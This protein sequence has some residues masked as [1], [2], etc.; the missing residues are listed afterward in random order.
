MRSWIT[1]RIAPD[2]AERVD[3]S[4]SATL[5]LARTV[6]LETATQQV[7]EASRSVATVRVELEAIPADRRTEV[8]FVDIDPADGRYEPLVGYDRAGAI[9]SRRSTCPAH[10]LDAREADA[11]CRRIDRAEIGS[12]DH[13]DRSMSPGRLGS[14]YD[15]IEHH[16]EQR[17][18]DDLTPAT[19]GF[20]EAAFEAF[21]QEPRRARVARSTAAARR[22]R[23]FQAFPWPTA[24]DEEWRR[25]DIRGCKLDAFAPAGPEEPSAEDR[26][27]LDA[28]LGDPELALRHRHRAGQRRAGRARPIPRKLGGAVFVDLAQAVK[29]HPE[30]LER[31]LLTEAV[32]PAADVFAALH[33][34]FWTG[35]T[36]LYVPKGVKVE[37]PL[38]SLVGLARD[39]R[40]DMNHT[41]VVLEEGAEATLVR[42]TAGR[43]RG[44]APALH[45]GA[46]EIFVGRGARL[47]FVNIQNWDAATWHFSRERALVGPRRRAAVD[48]RRPRLAAR[49]GQPGGRPGR[50]RGRGP[51]QRRHV[52]HRP[53]APGLLHPAGPQSPP[54]PPATCSTRGASRTSRGSSGRG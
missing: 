8:L 16:D 6:E 42:E 36:L 37:A 4:V 48:R 46:V 40:V 30:L 18:R 9:A 32:T 24:R 20:T 23:R 22:S 15:E 17:I 43:G 14:V 52:H 54:T 44:D 50:A 19:G 26:A 49:Q 29:D 10:R 35:G 21:L 31:Y 13:A 1:R 7:V 27:A 2:S 5:E 3:E 53:A 47:R 12:A 28:A 39:G 33:A 51:G 11:T 41:L 34:A 25:T 45:V 38:F